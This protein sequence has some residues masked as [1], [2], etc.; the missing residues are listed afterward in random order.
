MR[1][2]AFILASTMVLPV[3]ATAQSLNMFDQV[4]F[5]AGLGVTYGP[6]YMRSEDN[7]ASPWFI[8][9]NIQ[10][11]EDGGATQGI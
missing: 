9:R 1:I 7:D 4:S 2:A 11:G 8:L 6:E 10:L 5:D 3:A